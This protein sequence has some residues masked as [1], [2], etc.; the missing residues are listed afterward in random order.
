MVLASI[1]ALQRN[2]DKLAT[3]LDLPNVPLI[4]G[5]EADLYLTPD[6][7][8]V[9]RSFPNAIRLGF[10]ATPEWPDGRHVSEIWGPIIHRRNLKEAILRGDAP[11]PVFYLFE[12]SVD[13]D[14]TRI[15]SGDYARKAM[16]AALREAEIHSAIPEIYARLVPD[17]KRK[18]FPCL[19]FVPTAQLVHDTVATLKKSIGKDVSVV[20]WTGNTPKGDL[21]SGTEDF[22]AGRLD[23]LV[24]CE[25]GGRALDLPNA[26]VLIDG[27]P[28]LSAT[29]LE[30]RHGRVLRKARGGSLWKKPFAI[31]AQI[32]PTSAKTRP[33]LLP[34]VLDCWDDFQE[35]RAL[36]TSHR[37]D[38][39]GN[40]YPESGAPIGEEVRALRA[41]IE[42]ASP[43]RF[44]SLVRRIDAYREL[45][46]R[47]ELPKTDADGFVHT[48][49]GRL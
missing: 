39:C 1:Q 11:P 7:K 5:D 24:L 35:G 26:R 16:G 23:V 22:K 29:K 43:G 19:V 14:G 33:A 38:A 9:V 15:D 12:S 46:L 48:E 31:I 13:L 27:Y 17:S 47:S 32:V 42:N 28:T 37:H 30:Q 20:G 4:V 21:I 41:L 40:G 10:T 45:R 8:A 49:E 25:I 36:G 44:V 34:D 18:D 3:I 2:S 6:R